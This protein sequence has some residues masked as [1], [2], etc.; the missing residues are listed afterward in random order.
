MPKTALIIV[1]V[2]ND[3][4]E[5]GN[6][7][8]GDSRSIIDPINALRENGRYAL[9]VLT[10]DWHPADHSSFASNNEGAEVMSTITSPTGLPGVAW[11][12]HCVQGSEGAEFYADLKTKNTD[13]VVRKGTDTAVDSYSGFMD[14]DKQTKTDLEKILRANGITHVHIVGLAADY[15][16]GFTALDAVDAGFNATLFTDCT[17][18]VGA[19][20]WGEMQAKLAEK[21]V[22]LTESV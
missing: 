5:G 3:F 21:G 10:Q 16:V 19:D 4:M 18:P 8:V 13:V 15:C 22:T 17:R 2:Q 7:A 9:I 6:L 11:P 1:D 12:D 20:S 14:N